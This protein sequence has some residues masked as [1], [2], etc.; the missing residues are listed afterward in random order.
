MSP[1]L[2]TRNTE[3][4]TA[5]PDLSFLL[6]LCHSLCRNLPFAESPLE[7]LKDFKYRPVLAY[8]HN[9]SASIFPVSSCL[10]FHFVSLCAWVLE[11]VVCFSVWVW[12]RRTLSVWMDL[13][14]G[15][16]ENSGSVT[17]PLEKV[18]FSCS[19]FFLPSSLLSPF[20]F[21]SF[22]AFSRSLQVWLWRT[23]TYSLTEI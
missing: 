7:L 6:G 1:A 23:S 21:F 3:R 8:L 16:G 9:L 10:F 18:I 5:N 11:R 4:E 19:L 20:P 22:T 15:S 14:T 13:H 12:V 17:P 2:Y